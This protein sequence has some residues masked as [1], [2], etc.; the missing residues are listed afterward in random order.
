MRHSK[1][2]VRM[3]AACLSWAVSSRLAWAE[4]E[5]D[6][7]VHGSSAEAPP[8][9]RSLAGSVVRGDRLQAP[10]QETADLLRQQPGIGVTESGGHGSLSVA[11][12]RGA[13]SAETP[14][15][16]GGIRLNDD[17]GGTADLSLVPLWFVHHIEIYRGNAPVEA[18]QLGIGGAI[19]F[20][21]RRP[22]G[23]EASVGVASGSFGDRGGWV[24]SGFGDAT[25]GVLVG[26]HYQTAT[27]DY[28]FVDDHGKRFDL[29][30]AMLSHRSNADAA[31]VDV[32][33]LG[34]IA[35]GLRA[36]I[37]T[38][39]NH[40][41]RDQGLPGLSLFSTIAARASL[42]RDLAGVRATLPCGVARRCELI[43][44]T[45]LI[46]SVAKYDDPLREVALG[47]TH[48]QLGGS[49]V[50]E[51]I[52]AKW[53]A[54]R[55][56]EIV[57][58][59]GAAYDRLHVEEAGDAGR[60]ARRFAWR[61]SL[62]THWAAASLVELRAV[63]R[64]TCEN[65]DSLTGTSG[66]LFSKSPHSTSSGCD[67]AFPSLRLGA[68][69]GSKSVRVLLNF[70]RYE[71]TPTLGELYGISGS[72]RGNA[73][74]L[75]EKGTSGEIGLRASGPSRGM[76]RGFEVD[77]FGYA[78]V[79]TD[80]VSYLRASQGYVVPFNVG[81]TRTFGLESLLSW[82]RL[83]WLLTSVAV[84]LLDPRDLGAAGGNGVLPFQSRL[85][86]V[87]RVELRTSRVQSF[88]LK[89]ASVACSYI[90]QTSRYYDAAGL[91]VIPEQGSL[92]A[93]AMLEM[94]PLVFR[95]RVSNILDQ[96]RFDLV[97]YPLPGRAAYASLEGRF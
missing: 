43:L 45:S 93:D 62:L 6:V 63:A 90:Y 61:G 27:N 91:V 48:T 75:P 13:T 29:S 87:P 95:M 36:R 57:P 18:D 70:S 96:T 67:N 81:R 64:I 14:I 26:V 77:V 74:L 10:G 28:P 94:P 76:L 84:T 20:E 88:R 49:R 52:G 50:E 51:N 4:D 83:R 8:K 97:G 46:N 60:E 22:R 38:T 21:P 44:T 24:R 56:L 12:I 7:V 19:F 71:R 23:P 2:G 33:G 47:S 32:W 66:F 11:S 92:D 68:E 1:F 89:S 39:I 55:T 3:T 53:Q 17:V 80:L 37:D 78:R 82:N 85:V 5:T 35:V 58:Y 34:T 30:S 69:I 40:V 16:L 42:Q 65:T 15:Y 79:V 9:D 72:V 41:Q 54:L 25:G 73:A 31:T 86:F 59:I